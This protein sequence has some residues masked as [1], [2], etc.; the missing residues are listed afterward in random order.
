MLGLAIVDAGGQF[1]VQAVRD[2]LRV[3]G[4]AF[5]ILRLVVAEFRGDRRATPEIRLPVYLQS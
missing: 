4:L 1:A 3:I 2:R 5:R